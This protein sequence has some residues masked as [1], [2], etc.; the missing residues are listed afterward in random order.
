MKI[1]EYQAK[2]LFLKYNIP[3]QSGIVINYPDN[4]AEVVDRLGG[5]HW[6]VKAQVLAG[7][8]GKSGGVKLARSKEEV[9][10]HAKQI[11]GMRL[12]TPQTDKDGILVRKVLITRAEE[13][14][15][16]YY[17]SL[18]LDRTLEKPAIVI[19]R[20]GGIDI[21][22]IANEAPEKIHKVVI[23]P[24]IGLC[25]FQ[26]REII[27]SFQFEEKITWQISTFLRNLYRF[28]VETDAEMIEI[29]P[30][31][32]T[33][34]DLLI[35]LDAKV[36]FDDNALGRQKE[37]AEMKDF[38]EEEKSEI[39]AKKYGLSYV[40]LNGNVG[41]MVNGAGLAMSTMDLIKYEGGEP[42][43]F[44]DVGGGASAE[45]V[46]KGFGIIL[47]DP[48]VKAIF[49][50]IFGGIVRCDRIANG[51]IKATEVAHIKVPVVVRLEGTNS[52]KAREILKNSDI[53]NL[54]SVNGL[55]DG[56]LK[57]VKIASRT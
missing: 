52:E 43:N 41:I 35:A 24:Q 42:A 16:E 47:K 55:E 39:E 46:A 27:K 14:K 13:I 51:I 26:I 22:K 8:R 6:M 48:N 17:L 33:E 50:N 11:I 57:A 2:D 10:K 3:T 54:I 40:K 49:V 19:S 32:L 53:E 38:Y 37:I 4:A 56:A 1:H 29:N 12:R 36:S 21:E 44:L 9:I 45:T 28:Y 34:G 25:R 7:G 20:E 15:K 30:L 18:I 23:D 5:N 31:V